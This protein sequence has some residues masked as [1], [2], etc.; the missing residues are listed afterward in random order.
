[1]VCLLVLNSRVQAQLK[2]DFS[3]DKTG[4]C[5]PLTVSF[6]NKS[7]GTSSNTVYKWDFGN[8]NTAAIP[9]PGAIYTEE[10]TYTVTL[11]ATDGTQSSVKT[12]Q[13]TVYSK[14][15]IDFSAN[16][17]KGCIPFNVAFTSNATAG[18]GS[19]ASYYWD[20]GDGVTQQGFGN[21]QQHTYIETQLATVSLTV[22]NSM[23]CVNTAVKK[24]LIRVIPTLNAA[25]S[26]DKRILCRETD[27]V[28]FTNASAGPG[29]LSYLWDFGDGTTSTDRNPAHVFGKRGIYTVKLTV[30][31]SE[32]CVVS[33][34]QTGFINV[35]TFST[36]FNMPA[37]V[38]SQQSVQFNSVSS[39]TANNTIWEVDGTPYSYYGDYFYHAFNT[40]GTYK[41]KLTNTYGDCIDSAV[42]QITVKPTPTSIGFVATV[43]G[44]CG[45]P[46]AVDFKDTSADAVAWQWNFEWPSGSMQSSVQ[47]PTY[48]FNENRLYNVLL[49][50]TNSAG[51]TKEIVQPVNLPYP[52]VTLSYT[53]SS[54]Y[55]PLSNCGPI[56]LKW[57][58][59]S[60]WQA[61]TQYRWDFGDGGTSTEAEPTYTFSKTGNWQIRLNY[62]TANGC[63]G[64]A[65]FNSVTIYGKPTAGFS[66]VSGTNICGNTPVVFSNQS[67]GVVNWVYWYIN[68]VNVASS[69]YSALVYQFQEEGKYTIKM[70]ANNGMCSDTIEKVDY[71]TVSPPFPKISS[72]ANTCDGTRG[73]VTFGNASK[74]VQSYTWDFGD[75]ATTTLTT[76]HATMSHTYT[77]TGTYKVVLSTTNGACTVR[78]S[79]IVQVMLKKDVA[80]TMPASICVGSNLSF[81]LGDLQDNPYPDYWNYNYYFAKWEYD[82]GTQF[83]GYMNN[84]YYI[85]SY[86]TFNGSLQPP[87]PSKQKMRV[88]LQSVNFGCYDTS[89]FAPIKIVGPQAAME[90]VN[91]EVCF[92]TPVTFRDISVVTG[93]TVVRR[94][95]NFGDGQVQTSTGNT[96]T[97]TYTNPGS[98]YVWLSIT[99]HK[100][101]TGT[102]PQYTKYVRIN[103]PKA[104]FFASA[105]N[106][107]LS[108]TVS[109]YNNT[110]NYGDYNTTYNWDFGDGVTST[111]YSPSHTYT[112][113]GTYTAKL[114]VTNAVTGCSSQ[115]TQVIIVRDFNT[116]FNFN[117]AYI[118]SQSCPPV[119][120]R[121]N[122]TSVNYIR[123]DW[124]FGDG[125]RVDNVNYP[126]HIYEK[127]GKY[128]ITLYG[129]GPNGLTGTHKDSIVIEAPKA[130]LQADDLE[131]CIGNMVTL[132]AKADSTKSYVWDFGDGHVVTTTDTFFA[133]QYTVP[134]IYTPKLLV[135]NSDG[136]SSFASMNDKITIRPNP[137][138]GISPADPVV[139]LGQGKQLQATGGVAYSWTPATGLSNNAIAS[140]MASP[141][142][143]TSYTVEVADDIGCKNTGS[144]TVRVQA[145][146]NVSA[147]PEL[148]VCAGN[149]IVIPATGT[150][151]YNWINNTSG[152]NNTDIPNPTATPAITTTYTVTGSDIHKCFTDTAEVTVRVL[153]LP[154]VDAGI[155]YEVQAGTPVNLQPTYSNDV[156]QWAWSPATYL[157]CSTC[158]GPVSTPL[159]QTRYTLTV[160]N[161]VGCIAKDSMLIKMTCDE[162]KVAVPNAFSPNADGKND[163]FMIK[164]ISIIKHM[165]IFNR[166]GQKVFERNNFIAADRSACW[167]GTLNGYPASPGTYVYF[168]EMQCP[169]GGMF[170][171]KGSFVLVR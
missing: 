142:T 34:T 150:A 57:A 117:S 46:V 157:N 82:D 64:V 112:R 40:P 87:D 75:G 136:C 1:M 18:S 160:K 12:Q 100:G 143:T 128:I 27:P 86:P 70:I 96:I 36:N 29:T 48:T 141:V 171:R 125:I 110:N 61:I 166:W 58:A 152:L 21:T 91:D 8:G 106:V 104:A 4:G 146:M 127:P 72:I 54:N 165:V 133:H 122:N 105:T 15:S 69:N 113:A 35:A 130:T 103:G 16:A 52:Y 109:F 126:S 149:S 147:P 93:T 123:V 158:P 167:D 26:A 9:N 116:A 107:P 129:Y 81:T 45:A 37:Q 144:I 62:T 24:D 32:G 65:Y 90:I 108:T 85:E 124:D 31:S 119:L 139:F 145:P 73:E 132:F 88:I 168:V 115:F 60:T 121:F 41:I 89:N 92:N 98:Y 47:A 71:I 39:P 43:K 14:P 56:T 3:V 51:C 67:T 102:T 68:D 148:S 101:C 5:S 134:G 63:T 20:F 33:G 2:A 84:N 17:A 159:A 80:L 153:P 156:I 38:C 22:T 76:D 94:E 6:T 170:T 77:R 120:V 114:S 55:P 30:T 78:D 162:A 79:G 169:A 161:N 42:K 66:S 23:G 164:G 135:K 49:K 50:V 59:T 111:N 131:G 95:W 11:T 10:K 154:V 74:K 138:V 28:Q 53:S 99:D 7:T 13:I 19:I 137:T 163:V 140:P 25:F 118:T 155:D 151:L 44:Q 97:H 83:A